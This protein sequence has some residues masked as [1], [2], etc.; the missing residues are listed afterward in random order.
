[1]E[2]ELKGHERTDGE[3]ADDHL[4]A[5]DEEDD[6]EHDADEAV[7]HRIERRREADQRAVALDVLAIHP[8]EATNLVILLA[9]RAHHTNTGQVL[10][11]PGRDVTEV[12]LHRFVAD[13]NLLSEELHQS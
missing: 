9:E 7:Q 6:S 8:L 13:V 10:L 3:A 11:H 12:V 1:A 5:A 4:A 2:V